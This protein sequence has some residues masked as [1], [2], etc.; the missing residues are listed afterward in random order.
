MNSMGFTVKASIIASMLLTGHAMAQSLPDEINHT[1]Y[2]RIYQNLGQILEE[3]ISKHEDLESRQQQLE[4]SISTM[5]RQLVDLPDR[6][7]ELKGIIAYKRQEIGSLNEHLRTLE[8]DLDKLIN[9]IRYADRIL[10][11]LDQDIRQEEIRNRNFKSRRQAQHQVVARINADLQKE[12]KEERTIAQKITQLRNEINKSQKA[13]QESEKAKADLERQVEK[14]RAELGQVRSSLSQNQSVLS[15]KQPLLNDVK[16]QLPAVRS[17]LSSLRSQLSSEESTLNQKKS[18]LAR[19]KGDQSTDHS[20]RIQN[21]E[22]EVSSLNS[23]IEGKR[24][25]VNNLSQRENLINGQIQALTSDIQKLESEIARLNK[26]IGEM[27]R[28]INSFPEENR[29]IEARIAALRNEINRDITA[30]K[31]EEGK[32]ARSQSEVRKVEQELKRQEQ[33][34]VVV[35]QEMVNSDQILIRLNGN[36]RAELDRREQLIRYENDTRREYSSTENR[37]NEAERVIAN[38]LNEIQSNENRLASI[39]RE[40]PVVRRNLEVLIPQVVT[41]LRERT[42]AQKNAD[43]ANS[44]YRT[45]LG[46]YQRYLSEAHKLGED[47]AIIGTGDGT[48]AGEK[49]AVSTGTRLA[50]ENAQV[51]AKWEALRR[52]YVRGEITGYQDGY[53]IGHNSAADRDRGDEEGRVAGANRARNY[54]NQV[55]KPELYQEE[56]DRRLNDEVSLRKS[57]PVLVMRDE[58]S[59]VSSSLSRG[60]FVIPDLTENEINHSLQIISSLDGLIEQS[61]VELKQILSL[62]EKIREAKNVYTIPGPGVNA[63]KVDCA[64]VYKGVKDYLEAC[65]GSYVI[66]YENLYNEAHKEIF[67]KKYSSVFNHRVTEAFGPELV[68]LYPGYLAEGAKVGKDVGIAVGKKDIYQET[69]ERS[70]GNSY[71]LNLPAEIARVERESVEM[72]D[73]HLKNN[74]AVTL[75]GVSKLNPTSRY[76][77]APGTEIGLIIPVKNVGSR[78]S[79][80]NALLKLKSL[81]S[82]LSV[83]RK[84]LPLPSV[85]ALSAANLDVLKLRLSDNS[86]PGTKVIVKGEIIYPGHDYISSRTEQFEVEQEVSI[87]AEINMSVLFEKTP[88]VA[89]RIIGTIKTHAVEVKLNPKFIGV[90]QGYEVWMEEVGTNYATIIGKPEM[91]KVLER[92]QEQKVFLNYKLS[93]AARGK[94]ILFRLVI[95]NNG[96]VIAGQEMPV[97]AI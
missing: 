44:Q 71:T 91:T 68:R 46:L 52:G 31:Q 19:L 94:E 10:S 97:K 17:E 24:R 27:E 67:S 63:Q 32:L 60:E 18:E 6:N 84:E 16:N 47:K 20:A 73:G 38:S 15:A 40:L 75:N 83:E 54:V 8:R 22:Q 5:E 53:V 34:L 92:G 41:A 1:Q 96:E 4:I 23:S 79:T 2:L 80:G 55:V 81:S 90:D 64:A 7:S 50:T 88:R 76:G 39:Q 29:K 61:K 66:R 93:K 35:T 26:R 78:A 57:L 95:K 36:R 56:Y 89:V 13:V 33:I 82:N 14:D 62:R 59:L 72:V 21:L 65:K 37:R 12:I 70:E 43:E 74:P 86:V 9:E 69:F 28:G 3:K 45:R 48:R 87:N 25:Q 42:I 30:L 11:S 85:N 51:E 77:V 49:D 58:L